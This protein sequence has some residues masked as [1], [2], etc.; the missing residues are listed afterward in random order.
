MGNVDYEA[1]EDFLEEVFPEHRYILP[2]QTILTKLRIRT[3]Y[4]TMEGWI[5]FSKGK[6]YRLI[7]KDDNTRI[8][9]M[10]D[11]YIVI[12]N[13]E[14][15]DVF[16]DSDFYSRYD[17]WGYILESEE[18]ANISGKIAKINNRKVIE[19]K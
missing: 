5:V 13:E 7:Y 11:G 9:L 12:V 17:E 1:I 6:S 19:V 15:T 14:Y 8:F 16:L 4:S 3:F 18:V 10:L 2:N